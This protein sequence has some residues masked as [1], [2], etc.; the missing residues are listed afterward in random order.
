MYATRPLGL[1]FLSQRPKHIN[2]KKSLNSAE[3][4]INKKDEPRNMIS[5]ADQITSN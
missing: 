2:M 3:N 4:I 5:K 1:G